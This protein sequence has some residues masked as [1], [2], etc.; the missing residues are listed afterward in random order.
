[1]QIADGSNGTLTTGTPQTVTPMLGGA[2][3]GKVTTWL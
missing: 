2:P 3:G 1:M